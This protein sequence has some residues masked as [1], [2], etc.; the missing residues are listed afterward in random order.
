[1]S[2][3]FLPV[4]TDLPIYPQKPGSQ[5]PSGRSSFSRTHPRVRSGWSERIFLSHRRAVGLARKTFEIILGW[6][7]R[8][9]YVYIYA[10]I[11]NKAML[12]PCTPGRP[13]YEKRKGQCTALGIDN[14]T[15][16][17]S[18]IYDYSLLAVPNPLC[19]AGELVT[20]SC[21]PRLVI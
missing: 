2:D 3:E 8:W 12:P 4:Q 9:T 19:D 7:S 11:I 10:V 21:D 15:F 13:L 20:E 18:R 14:P 1:M 16:I 17:Y 5:S 6:G